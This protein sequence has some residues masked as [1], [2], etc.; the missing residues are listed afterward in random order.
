M[1]RRARVIRTNFRYITAAGDGD[2][3]RAAPRRRGPG[4]G[5]TRD[6]ENQSGVVRTN[7][8][9]RGGGV[10][11]RHRAE[12][13]RRRYVA[14]RAPYLGAAFRRG[15]RGVFDGRA[16][17]GRDWDAVPAHGAAGG[18][19]A[20]HC[21]FELRAGVRAGHHCRREHLRAIRRELLPV[22]F[23]G[24]RGHCGVRRNGDKYRKGGSA[25][26]SGAAGARSVRH[27]VYAGADIFSS[28]DG[29]T[30]SQVDSAESD[31]LDGTYDGRVWSRR[32]GHAH[33]SAGA[34]G[35][36]SD[37]VDA[38]A[39]RAAGLDSAGDRAPDGAFQ[40]VGMRGDV[41]GCGSGVGGGG[42]E[43][44]S[45]EWRVT[46]RKGQLWK[47]R[48]RPRVKSRSENLTL[49]GIMPDE[50]RSALSQMNWRRAAF[51]SAMSTAGKQS[52]RGGR[53]PGWE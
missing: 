43:E 24:L 26:T 48:I 15:H 13:A 3:R 7:R 21:V 28:R 53:R 11:R 9:W 27:F 18:G 25:R 4:Q 33:Q 36:A 39:V 45:D 50:S 23:A 40:L 34:A 10:F 8:L 29:A 42:G 38:G 6:E 35:D 37:D 44:S 51:A 41:F 46:T 20:F 12:V 49:D 17:C 14:K 1:R 31:V 2:N 5:V 32:S 52:E 22:L 47:Q 30:G 16:G 19:G